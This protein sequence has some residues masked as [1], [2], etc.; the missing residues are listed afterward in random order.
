MNNPE[1]PGLRY[2]VQ[3]TKINENIALAR[4][5]DHELQ[6]S[7]KKG[8]N[9]QGFNAVETL[10]AALGT[11]VL[12]NIND[13][14]KKL[15]LKINTAKVKL[16]AVRSNDPPKVESIQ[17]QL[18]IQS[19]EDRNK[20]EELFHLS[21]KWGTVTNTLIETVDISGTLVINVLEAE[22]DENSDLNDAF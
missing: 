17:Y 7:I 14:S 18:I 6:V 2:A 9:S 3:V 20:L 4:R 11:C 21:Q 19:D 16:V 1:K 8:D 13:F 10:L 5:D 22:I 15:R 12:T